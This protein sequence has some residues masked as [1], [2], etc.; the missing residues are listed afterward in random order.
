MKAD[1]FTVVFESE[2][3]FLQLQARSMRRNL[4]PAS[5]GRIIVV[6]NGRTANREPLAEVFKADVLPEYGHLAPKV[7]FLPYEYFMKF[8]PGIRGYERQ[9]IIKLRGH[10]A[11][12]CGHYITLDA[13]NFFI[14][15]CGISE[16]FAPDGK[17]Y[18]RQAPAVEMLRGGPMFFNLPAEAN[19]KMPDIFTPF[20]IHADTARELEEWLKVKHKTTLPDV[21]GHR[22]SFAHGRKLYPLYEYVM[23][24]AFIL[25]TYG[26]LT[27]LY[28]VRERSP[29]LTY[30]CIVPGIAGAKFHRLIKNPQWKIIGIHRR[31]TEQSAA[32]KLPYAETMVDVGLCHTVQEAMHFLTNIDANPFRRYYDMRRKR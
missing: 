12:S 27:P 10:R 16:F 20:T 5:V 21:I 11:A 30:L 26:D 32:Y 17:P 28:H 25:K 4:D 19:A 3:R 7:D 22:R 8:D 13:K 1:F 29:S 24:A 6:N 14:R 9:Q 15:P 31:V 2:I 18:I 23:Y